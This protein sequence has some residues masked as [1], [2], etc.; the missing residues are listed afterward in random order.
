MEKGITKV[1]MRDK[2]DE[3]RGGGGEEIGESE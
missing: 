2:F 1:R 3:A